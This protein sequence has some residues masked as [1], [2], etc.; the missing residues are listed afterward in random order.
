MSTVKKCCDDKPI[1]IT[2]N[3]GTLCIS[4]ALIDLA[5]HVNVNSMRKLYKSS[6]KA[7]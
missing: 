1:I 6:I 4:C 3:K 5:A 2:S 7:L